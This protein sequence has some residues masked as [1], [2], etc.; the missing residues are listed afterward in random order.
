MRGQR[1]LRIIAFLFRD[2]SNPGLQ[3]VMLFFQPFVEFL[4]LIRK[5]FVN[6]PAF[7]ADFAVLEIIPVLILGFDQSLQFILR[8]AQ[9]LMKPLNH[10]FTE[11]LLSYDFRVH[12]NCV[13]RNIAGQ[14]TSVTVF[15]CSPLSFDDR[16]MRPL[17]DC[18]FMPEIAL[19]HLNPEHPGD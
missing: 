15:D 9:Q 18:L 8:F 7:I 3:N 11:P 2:K 12:N 19:Q 17:G 1:V 6:F 4:H 10:L 16:G 14:N 5:L 13:S